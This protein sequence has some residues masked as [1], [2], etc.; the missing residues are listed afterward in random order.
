MDRLD[1]DPCLAKCLSGL[2]KLPG[3]SWRITV[4]S[5][6][7]ASGRYAPASAQPGPSAA[8]VKEFDLTQ[9]VPLRDAHPIESCQDLLLGEPEAEL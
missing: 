8:P 4:N 2:A 1:V 9:M 7:I 3:A 6:A 5:V